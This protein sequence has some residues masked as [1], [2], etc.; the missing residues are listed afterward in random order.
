MADGTQQTK[1]KTP[2][3]AQVPVKRL[4]LCVNHKDRALVLVQGSSKHSYKP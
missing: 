3:L 1:P 2:P 4:R